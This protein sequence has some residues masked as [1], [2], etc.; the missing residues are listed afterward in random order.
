MLIMIGIVNLILFYFDQFSTIVNAS[1][2]FLIFI[3]LVR[4]RTRFLT[5]K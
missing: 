2:Q 3:L 5:K 4:F 1:I